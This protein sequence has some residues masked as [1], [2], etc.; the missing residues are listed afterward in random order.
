MIRDDFKMIDF[1]FI[2]DIHNELSHSNIDE[3]LTLNDIYKKIEQLLIGDNS[4]LEF[5]FE[6]RDAFLLEYLV[7]KNDTYIDIFDNLSLICDH[8]TI[9]DKFNGD[10][11]KLKEAYKYCI[12]SSKKTC[13]HLMDM[14]IL[15]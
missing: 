1:E 14:K 3:N 15:K 8:F 4:T 9:S 11:N 5:L 12:Y 2:I 6:L 13:I 7:F 10:L